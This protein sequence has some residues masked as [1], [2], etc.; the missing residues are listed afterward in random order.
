MLTTAIVRTSCSVK[1]GLEQAVGH[2]G[3]PVLDRRVRRL[4]EIGRE[5]VVLAARSRGSPRRSPPRRPCRYG[6]ARSNARASHRAR[7]AR[8]A[9][10]SG[11]PASDSRDGSRRPGRRRRRAPRRRPRGSRRARGGR[12]RARAGGGRRPRAR[13]RGRAV[14]RTGPVA[15]P[16]AANSSWILRQTGCLAG[17]GP[18]SLA[19]FSASTVGSQTMRAPPRAAISTAWAF[20]PPTPALSAIAPSASNRRARRRARRR[21]ARPSARS[22]T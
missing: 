1:P 20:S 5:H 4:A 13:V 21:P 10:R 3:E 15:T 14:S 17:F 19:S 16:A 12:W 18:S 7:R 9:R 11:R 6:S 2:Q 8:A 22:A